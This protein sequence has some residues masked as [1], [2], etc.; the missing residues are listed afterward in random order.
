[1]HTMHQPNGRSTTHLHE[2]LAV[3]EFAEETLLPDCGWTSLCTCPRLG[4]EG[5]DDIFS[6]VG[7]IM[8]LPLND[9]KS[10]ALVTRRFESYVS[11]MRGAGQQI[12]NEFFEEMS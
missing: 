11:L 8:Y 1:M 6:W 3:S 10:R 5:A 9:T 2:G 7:I 12:A 4:G